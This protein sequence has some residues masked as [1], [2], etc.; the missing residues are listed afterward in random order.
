MR[1]LIVDNTPQMDDKRTKTFFAVF[2]VTIGN[3]RRWLEKVTVEQEYECHFMGFDDG[4]SCEW[5]NIRFIDV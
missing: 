3:E 5:V 4:S 1:K 2:P